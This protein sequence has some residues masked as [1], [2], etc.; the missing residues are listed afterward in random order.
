MVDFIKWALTDGQK[1]APDLG[2]APLP[3]ERRR[4]GAEGARDRSRFSN[5]GP[6]GDE[7]DR[8]PVPTNR[9]SA[10]GRVCSRVLVIAVV[11]GDRRGARSG[12]RG[13]RSQQF[14][15]QF[16]QTDIWDPVAGRVRRAAVH[17][18]HALFVGAGADHRHADR[19]RHRH[20]HLGARAG[21]GCSGRWCSSRN[22]SPR[23]P[24]S[25]T[26]CGASSC[27]CPFVRQ[28]EIGHARRGC[29]RVPLFSGP[30]LGRRHAVRGDRPRDHG[31][32]VH[33]VGRARGAAGGARSRSAKG[34]TRSARRAGRRSAW[35]SSTR[36]PASSARS[37]WASAVRSARRWR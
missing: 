31:D 7:S 33:L 15:W 35:R 10:S 22:C 28:L 18:G 27:W 34:P 30:P 32:P 26:A 37:C 16:W 24:P 11:V 6:S 8:R 5:R 9:S 3:E 17:L 19:A 36:A 12:N 13:S 14:G 23:F 4:H 21:A 29:K 25:S 2:Y 1:F 20:L